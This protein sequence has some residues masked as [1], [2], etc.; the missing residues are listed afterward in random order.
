ML[1]R[2]RWQAPHCSPTQA[3]P[4]T[5]D[6]NAALVSDYR[7]R[8]FSRTRRQ[9]TLQANPN[10]INNSTGV[11]RIFRLTLCKTFQSLAPLGVIEPRP[12]RTHRIRRQ[13]IAYPAAEM[14]TPYLVYS[15]TKSSEM[16]RLLVAQILGSL[17]ASTL[18]EFTPHVKILE[19]HI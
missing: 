15:S 13:P 8:R 18:N 10:T 3:K 12:F 14:S 5:M 17:F 16:K 1:P 9:P 4:T 2:L 19:T 11:C 6:G 7:N